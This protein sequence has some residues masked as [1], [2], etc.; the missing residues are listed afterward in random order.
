VKENAINESFVEEGEEEEENW[1]KQVSKYAREF[2]KNISRSNIPNLN[3]S[4]DPTQVQ[5]RLDGPLFVPP[6]SPLYS[7]RTYIGPVLRTITYSCCT[8]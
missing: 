1:G 8:T 6:H 5:L 3:P 7:I 2:E 4:D